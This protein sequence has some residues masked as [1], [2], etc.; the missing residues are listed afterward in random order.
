MAAHLKSLNPHSDSLHD[1]WETNAVQVPDGWMPVFY[2]ESGP[3][4][5]LTKK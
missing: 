5:R 2:A 4:P 3:S 1:S